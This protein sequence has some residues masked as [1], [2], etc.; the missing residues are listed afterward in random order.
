MLDDALIHLRYASN[1]RNLHFITYD[2]VNPT[3]GTSSL[4]YVAILA[5]LRSFTTS[6][7]LP[8]ILSDVT[9]LCLIG[10]VLVLIYRLG[11]SR[12][13]QIACAGLLASLISPMGVRW[14]TDGMETSLVVLA[15]SL[16]AL[17]VHR[18]MQRKSA[19]PGSY[20]LLCLFGACLAFLRIELASLVALASL[21]ILTARLAVAPNWKA[22]AR[23]LLGSSH[24]LLG[25]LIA[26]ALLHHEFGSL[27]PDTAVAK[28]MSGGAHEALTA[29]QETATAA[30]TVASAF[31]LGMGSALLWVVSASFLL[32]T[33]LLKRAPVTSIVAWAFANAP[34]PLVMLLAISRGQ[35]LQGIRY[36]LWCF[37]FSI[38]WNA[39]TLN[40]NELEEAS[41]VRQDPLWLRSVV[42]VCAVFL[43]CALPFDWLYAQRAMRGR[44]GTFAAMRS[45]GLDIFKGETLV[46]G[47]VGFIGYFSGANVCDL[48]GLVN[49]REAARLGP[50]ERAYRCASESPAVL[51]VREDQAKDLSKHIDL[52]RWVVCQHFDFVNVRSLDRHYLV[53]PPQAAGQDCPRMGGPLGKLDDFI[54]SL[55]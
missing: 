38:L 9:Y 12:P 14:L 22:K 30:Q 23:A 28:A 1:L 7:L 42:P 52:R 13:A 5:L 8:K 29:A 37:V 44:S 39:L 46:A 20:V 53:V 3:F 35:S 50:R 18:E 45:A 26:M 27:L 19:P 40:R 54:P 32:R 31:L 33:Y 47:D 25:V 2:G 48:S 55:D 17:L 6:P 51:F 36:F 21:A 11:A 15:A 4:L 43:V 34:F 16:L 41:S 49:G 24:L 10:F